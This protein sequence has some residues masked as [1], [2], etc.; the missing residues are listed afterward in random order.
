MRC[1][2]DLITVTKIIPFDRHLDGRR[3]TE[4][5]FCRLTLNMTTSESVET[6]QRC[7]HSNESTDRCGEWN[8]CL[9]NTRI[10]DG[11]KNC[12]N[13]SDEVE[14]TVSEVEESCV[15]VRRHR[16][17]CSREQPT[18]LSVV[19]LGDRSSHCRSGFD[20][21]WFRTGRRL[22]LVNCNNRWKDE[23][24]LLR[25]Y[26]EQSSTSIENNQRRAE[27]RI[28]FRS[29]CDTFWDLQSR[30]DENTRECRQSWICVEGQFK[31]HTGQCVQ[32][33]WVRDA[34]WDCEDASDEYWGL[35]V[36]TQSALQEASLHNF[37]NRSYSIPS[38]CN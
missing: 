14:K 10:L 23:C 28:S 8:P 38:H 25:Q 29:H 11:S 2:N 13:G 30:R 3:L 36:T 17:R 1:G 26:I 16:F 35:N 4:E 27:I 31:C 5:H 20:E 37:T 6:K 12:L 34:E 21:L 24:S 7:H 22:S 33:K 19:A 15:Q 9:S 32:Q 18:C